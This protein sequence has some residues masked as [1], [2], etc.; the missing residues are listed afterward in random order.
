MSDQISHFI[1][2]LD[3]IIAF[4]RDFPE[5]SG[6]RLTEAYFSFLGPGLIA[7]ARAKHARIEAELDAEDVPTV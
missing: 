3:K 4:K 7:L 6:P 2:A 5:V 1:E